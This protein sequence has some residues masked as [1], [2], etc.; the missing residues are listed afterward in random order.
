MSMLDIIYLVQNKYNFNITSFHFSPVS[1]GI[2]YTYVCIVQY[3][4]FFYAFSAL[5]FLFPGNEKAILSFKHGSQKS[6]LV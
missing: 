6:L 5:M 2:C 4:K 3:N 1:S